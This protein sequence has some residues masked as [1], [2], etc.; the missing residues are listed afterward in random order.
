MVKRKSTDKT[1]ARRKST[2]GQTT[3]YKKYVVNIKPTWESCHFKSHIDIA[4]YIVFIRFGF[5]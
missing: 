3:I 4:F 1:M 5:H 2:K